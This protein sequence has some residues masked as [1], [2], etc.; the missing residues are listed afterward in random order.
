MATD[1]AFADTPNRKNSQGFLIKLFG[2]L[3]LW[4]AGK[5]ATVTIS[6]IEAELLSLSAGASELYSLKRLF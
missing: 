6:T 5:Q 4:K 2:A 1:T 3:I